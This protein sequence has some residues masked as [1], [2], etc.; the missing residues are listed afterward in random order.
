M[1]L[2]RIASR[3]QV[4]ARCI[5]F[6]NSRAAEDDDRPFYSVLPQQEFR[7]EIVDFK[8]RSTNVIAIEEAW[9]LHRQPIAFA[10]E[11]GLDPLLRFRI[12]CI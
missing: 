5:W 11:D 12:V 10:L 3:L 8:P 2:L 9:I 1:P 7:F 6:T 4:A